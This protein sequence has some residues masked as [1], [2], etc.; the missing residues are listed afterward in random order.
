[1]GYE[2]LIGIRYLRSKHRSGFV[3]FV[4]IMSVLGLALG[5]TVLIVVLSV[6]NGFERELRSRMLSVT[7]HATISGL[8]GHIADWRALD[9]PLAQGASGFAFKVDNDKI[10]AREEQFAEAQIAMTTD[11]EAAEFPSE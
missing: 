3:S 8:D 11:A 1:M 6:L 2:W 7:S 10:P 9:V 4:A 5:V